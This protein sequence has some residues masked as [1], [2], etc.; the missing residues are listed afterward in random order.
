MNS[1]YQQIIKY[2]SHYD[3]TYLNTEQGLVFVKDNTSNIF[4][5]REEIIAEKVKEL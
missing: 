5:I 2:C 1:W 4:P 3:L